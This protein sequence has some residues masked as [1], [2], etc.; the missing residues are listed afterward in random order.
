MIK[1][2]RDLD[3]SWME[4]SVVRYRQGKITVRIDFDRDLLTWKDSN[5]WFNDFVRNISNLQAQA[6]KEK[7][8]LLLEKAELSQIFEYNP[9]ETFVWKIRL[10]K[11]GERDAILETGGEEADLPLWQD[12]VHEIE[13]AGEQLLDPI[14]GH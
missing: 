6:I 2:I 9:N 14:G 3:F 10:G 8:L 7:L 13:N 4:C 1:D 5:R 12:L 11:A